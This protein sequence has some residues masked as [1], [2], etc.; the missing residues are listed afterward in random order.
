M[1]IIMGVCLNGV[2]EFVAILFCIICKQFYCIYFL[3]LLLFIYSF[4][5][6]LL[7]VIVAIESQLN[8]D[9]KAYD[10]HVTTMW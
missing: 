2:L 4:V 1:V 8:S 5:V 10:Y 7:V 6:V 3:L 9:R